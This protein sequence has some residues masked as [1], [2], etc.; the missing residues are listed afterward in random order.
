[1]LDRFRAWHSD[2]RAV[3][4]VDDPEPKLGIVDERVAT[5][6]SLHATGPSA[7]DRDVSLADLGLD[8]LLALELCVALEKE[9]GVAL[10]PTFF[11]ERP[12]ASALGDAI[13]KGFDES[14]GVQESSK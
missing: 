13:C 12:S 1:M 2:P 5:V 3:I 7:L 6:L 10:P 4:T 14:C 9:L 11:A 8:S